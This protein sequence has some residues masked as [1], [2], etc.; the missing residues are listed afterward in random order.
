M[1]RRTKIVATLGPSVDDPKELESILRAGAD[2]IRINLSH[3]AIEE[4]L[5]RAA[6]VREVAATMDRPVGVLAD[7]PGPKIRAGRF[8]DDGA[9]LAP[10]EIVSLVPGDGP[11]D[12]EQICVEYDTLLLDVDLGDRVV[13]GDG[14]ISM[15]VVAATSTE[16]QAEIE[17][18]GR[19]QG[20]PGVHLSCERL[21][22]RA[23]TAEDLVLAEAVA[24]AG[25]DYIALSFVRRADDVHE[26]RKVVGDR[27][28]HHR[29]DRD[30]RR[31]RRTAGDR[32][33]GGRA[34]WSPAATSAIDCPLEDVPHLQKRIVRHCVEVGRPVITATQM[35]ES[36]IQSP[37]PTRAEVS[38]V[39]NAVFD[40]TDAVMLS[41]ET[42]IGLQP[43]PGRG[44]DGADRRSGRG[45]SQLP[46]V[47]G[48]A[49]T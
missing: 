36:M 28:G 48:A 32:R 16:L 5:H 41:G 45:G 18:G 27:A 26:L 4:H 25:V 47:G 6:M 29:Q 1:I 12:A 49:G 23:P 42:A 37:S 9:E 31:A 13:L 33:G 11:S 35:L 34:R 7:L 40:G 3:G 46:A 19:A 44:D 39:A 24:A 21:Q 43:A 10:G 2:V 30:E 22:M 14:A 20:R 15:R 38:D 8:P 17:S